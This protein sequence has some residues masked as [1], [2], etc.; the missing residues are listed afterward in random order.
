M[1]ACGLKMGKIGGQPICLLNFFYF[2]YIIT[3]DFYLY[4]RYRILQYVYKMGLNQFNLKI[5]SQFI[6][7]NRTHD[8]VAQK[9]KDTHG[10]CSD[11]A[12]CSN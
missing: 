6:S 4:K 7:V 8:F 5:H 10:D 12:Y 1:I 9:L 3:V 11:Q 2:F